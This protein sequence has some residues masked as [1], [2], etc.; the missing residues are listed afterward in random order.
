MGAVTKS[1][2]DLAF[3]PGT[4]CVADAG[5]QP[6]EE[7]GYHS[8]PVTMSMGREV[9]EQTVQEVMAAVNHVI[10]S[11]TVSISGALAQVNISALERLLGVTATGQSVI[12]GA[13]NPQPLEVALRLVTFTKDRRPMHLYIP[14]AHSAGNMES[15]FGKAEA[16][17][18]PFTFNGVYDSTL[19]GVARLSLG[20]AAETSTL[21]TGKAPRT[22]A[23]PGASIAWLKLAGEGGTADQL[24]DIEAAGGSSALADGEIVRLQISA[25]A[26]PITIKH[27]SGAIELKGAA[28]WV[29][30]K[31]T[32]WIDLYYDL[33]GT[34]WVEITRYDAP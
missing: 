32:D 8:D 24:D 17:K 21:A 23:N 22:N 26:A 31:L 5:T 18:F 25:V 13:G 30:N 33:T 16:T 3:G 11:E 2:N 10:Q 6:T 34:K 12:L 20:T 7:L 14:R 9:A 19:G 15:Q 29:M 27:A 1:T 4:L 28:D